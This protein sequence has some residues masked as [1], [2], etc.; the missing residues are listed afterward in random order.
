MARTRR[1]VQIQTPRDLND[2]LWL[3]S[4]F[5]DAYLMAGGTAMMSRRGLDPAPEHIIDLAGVT[6]LSRISRTE[7]W[8]EIGATLPMSRILSVGPH[9]IPAALH[10]AL[11][12]VAGP[13]VRNLATLGGNLCLAI[14]TSDSLAPLFALDCRV[15]VRSTN[16]S[17]WLEL[18]DFLPARGSPALG[19]AQVMTRIRVP[20]GAW[21][22]QVF[23]KIAP[24]SA[25]SFAVLSTC[26]LARVQKNT[27]S[28]LRF[29]AAG[30]FPAQD[31]APLVFRDRRLE[32][33][34]SGHRLPLAERV[35][36]QSM[37]SAAET[38]SRAGGASGYPADTAIRL[39]GWFLDHIGR[40]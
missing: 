25:P 3:H 37:E 17:R 35:I 29:A 31:G 27:L 34:L 32:L 40:G 4:E 16:G 14:P 12:G 38:L 23:R 33:N 26:G 36:E 19:P 7:R 15:E 2:L 24:K 9:V 20:A 30:V 18:Q 5:P 6:E 13:S 39:L 11:S 10:S 28:E 22:H 21:D 8:L 1:R